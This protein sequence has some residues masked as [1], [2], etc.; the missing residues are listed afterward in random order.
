VLLPVLATNSTTDPADVARVLV[1]TRW[2]YASVFYVVAMMATAF[3]IMDGTI[4]LLAE[5]TRVDA[6]FAQNALVQGSGRS[7]REGMMTM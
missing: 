7:M 4:L 3:F 5:L 6:Y 2:G 1:G